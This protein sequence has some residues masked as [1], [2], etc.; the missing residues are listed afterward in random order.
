MDSL[1]KFFV[2]IAKLKDDKRKGWTIFDISNPDTT[3][4]H[5]FRAALLVWVLN[6]EKGLDEGM[7]LK[8]IL[9]HHLPELFIGQE[10]PYDALL[11]KDLTSKREKKKFKE[12]VEELKNIPLTEEKL[13]AKQRF[14]AEKKAID[15][16]I[17]DM[18]VDVGKE[19]SCTWKKYITQST[20]EGKFAWQIG[21]LE[22]LIQAT[23]Y[24]I[25]NES[26]NYE[27][28]LKWSKKRLK[29]PLILD[30]VKAIEWKVNKTGK[31]NK[32]SVYLDL[33]LELGKLKKLYR[34]GW[35]LRGVKNPENVSQH[36]Y[37][38]A[39]MAWLFGHIKG[40]DTVRAIKIALVHDI[41]EVYAGDQTP[42][43]PILSI[44]KE[45]IEE[46][47]NKYPRVE[48]DKR[49]PWLIKKKD[50]EWK[51]MIKITAGL[52]KKDQEEFVNLWIDLEEGLTK[53]GRFVHQLDKMVNLFQAIEYWKKDKTFPIIP[54]WVD[55][56]E[57]IDDPDLL[58]FMNE[59]DKE[60]SIVDKRRNK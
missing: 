43:D 16:L 4:D 60:F 14:D 33:M 7:L 49:L 23:E 53:E 34:R 40:I 12:L 32:M 47:F 38:V 50:K 28:W 27:L 46:L 45:S 15:T 29:D 56:K 58:G 18:P 2:D 26:F 17:K 30:F 54:W 52:N 1:L 37:Q 19:I 35:V 6:K 44:K 48:L 41:C 36:T 42:Y 24:H 39:I 9:V 13:R 25:E 21:K 11:P 51:A 59:L 31:T 57:A 20:K 3:A 10:T 8:M 22:T 5:L 55:L